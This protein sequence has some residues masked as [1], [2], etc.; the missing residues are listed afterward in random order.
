M[1]ILIM[2]P[3]DSS[4][5]SPA[6]AKGKAREQEMPVHQTGQKRKNIFVCFDG[7][8]QCNLSLKYAEGPAHPK[9]KKSIESLPRVISYTKRHPQV[10]A[11]YYFVNI[12]VSGDNNTESQFILACLRGKHLAVRALLEEDAKRQQK[13]INV[14]KRFNFESYDS[15]LLPVWFGLLTSSTYMTWEDETSFKKKEARMHPY[16]LVMSELI[17]QKESYPLDLSFKDRFDKTILHLVVW[18]SRLNILP[19]YYMMEALMNYQVEKCPEFC[20]DVN[21]VDTEGHTALYLAMTKRNEAC[22]II[23][24]LFRGK[25]KPDLMLTFKRVPASHPAPPVYLGGSLLHYIVYLYAKS[26]LKKQPSDRATSDR[27]PPNSTAMLSYNSAAILPHNNTE[28][29]PPYSTEKYLWEIINAIFEYK[30]VDAKVLAIENDQ[31]QTVLMYAKKIIPCP[32]DPM[33]QRIQA[34]ESQVKLMYAKKIPCPADP[35][36]NRVQAQAGQSKVDL[37][38]QAAE[39]LDQDPG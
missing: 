38:L 3:T 19:K 16:W 33:L 27:V 25:V 24:S 20:F 2:N 15:G 5:G 17:A 7:D 4:S 9:K 23:S 35:M 37:L 1:E 39:M 11:A 34:K 6:V 22:T 28:V 8:G 31:S 13:E 29:L 14:N 10:R 26:I 32:K 18:N 12:K 30:V 36:L 21:A